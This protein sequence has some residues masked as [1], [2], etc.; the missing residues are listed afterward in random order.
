[1][2]YRDV[3]DARVFILLQ[4]ALVGHGGDE[5]W[6]PTSDLNVYQIVRRQSTG[7]DTKYGHS[8]ASAG[9]PL[10][11]C[12]STSRNRCTLHRPS[13]LSVSTLR[14]WNRCDRTL[15]VLD[16]ASAGFWSKRRWDWGWMGSSDSGCSS[17]SAILADFCYAS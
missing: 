10:R 3:Y 6:T 4:F 9:D 17:V 14:P 8:P 15:L 12:V 13:R 1:M 11:T 7:C 5:S 16:N 2:L